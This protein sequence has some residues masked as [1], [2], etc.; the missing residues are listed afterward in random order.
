MPEWMTIWLVTSRW[1]LQ[2][3]PSQASPPPILWH[4]M[5]ERVVP[6]WP[7]DGE[8]TGQIPLPNPHRK[9]NL[10]ESRGGREGGCTF[11]YI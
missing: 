4:Q 1:L 7:Q 3:E 6:S 8:P 2:R 5:I 10:E 11:S 9:Q